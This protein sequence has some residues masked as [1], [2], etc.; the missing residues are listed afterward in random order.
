M[1]LPGLVL[2]SLFASAFAA[3]AIVWKGSRRTEERFLHSS[4]EVAASDLLTDV[5]GADSGD[6]SLAAVFS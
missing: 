1:K 2:V 3:P 5:L 4:D 6:S